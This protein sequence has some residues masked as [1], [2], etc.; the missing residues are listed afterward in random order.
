MSDEI[1]AGQEEL[2]ESGF[3]SEIYIDIESQVAPS[4]LR[5]FRD[6][7]DDDKDADDYDCDGDDESDD[8]ED[9]E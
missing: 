9:D 8:E 5:R 2:D 3:L 6:D 4:L 1:E 7:D